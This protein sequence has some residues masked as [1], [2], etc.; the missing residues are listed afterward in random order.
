[1]SG[2]RFA[3][4]A[5][6]LAIVPLVLA[7]WLH[8]RRSQRAT[9]TYSNTQLLHDLPWTFSLAMSYALPWVYGL[10]IVLTIVALAR[11]QYGEEEFLL[12]SEGIAIEMCI[13]RSGSMLAEDFMLHESRM[14]RLQAVKSVFIEFVTGGERFEG[15]DN[16]LIGLIAFGGFADARCP[17]T[18]DHRALL[19]VLKSV[20]IAREIRDR[21]GRVVN[22]ELLQEE[23]ATA[24]GDALA[25]AVDRLRDIEAKSKIAILLSDGEN[26]AGVVSP[27]D[28][29]RVAKEFGIKVYTIGVGS[30]G[31]APFP[32]TDPFG[33]TRL[34][35]QPVSLD[36][37]TLRMIADE[38]GGMY[39]A[40]KDMDALE[41]V[42]REI[43]QLEKSETTGQI[44]LRYREWYQYLLLPGFTLL[45]V[46]L[47]LQSTWLRSLP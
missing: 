9:I 34:I 12:R 26:T 20:Q 1:M 2:F 16:D 27:A 17:L 30:T 5:W 32:Y 8:W 7:A 41:D 22:E 13:D 10:G 33:R 11:P 42:Y 35:S 18:L 24:I 25:L 44:F 36:E 21:F 39:F 6:L 15:R 46:A 38:T 40:A 3:N 23:R 37:S 43:D 28:A 31:M 47:L 4:P 45:V 14:N 19:E 29:A